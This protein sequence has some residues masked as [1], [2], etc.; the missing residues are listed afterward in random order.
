MSVRAISVDASAELP[1]PG[2]EIIRDFI[3]ASEKIPSNA[4]VTLGGK[5]LW[6]G[7]EKL[8]VRG[9]TYGTFRP[10]NENG[11]TRSCTTKG[12]SGRSGRML[13]VERAGVQATRPFLA[14]WLLMRFPQPSCDGMGRVPSNDL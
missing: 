3:P 7:Q 5:F 8:Y 13:E 12:L 1:V 6:L 9:V 11:T 10:G 2:P 14:M 4:R